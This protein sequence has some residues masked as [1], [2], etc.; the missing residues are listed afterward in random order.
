[1]PLK[2]NVNKVDVVG[3]SDWYAKVKR[4]WIWA[5]WYML[6]LATLDLNDDMLVAV[7]RPEY[8]MV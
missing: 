4:Y 7:V 6:P 8:E 2:V 5:P 1:M 3:M